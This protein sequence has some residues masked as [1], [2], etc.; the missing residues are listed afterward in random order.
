MMLALITIGGLAI[1][2]FLE[3][4]FTPWARSFGMWPTLTGRWIGELRTEDGRSQP[5]FFELSGGFRGRSTYINGRARV[6]DR[7]DAIRDFEVSGRPDNWRGTRFHFSPNGTVEIRP[8]LAAGRLEA[9]WSGDE[10]RGSGPLFQPGGVASASVSRDSPSPQTQ[11]AQLMLRRGSERDF[12]A[13]C[14]NAA[15]H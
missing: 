14:G 12:L 2:I 7:R 6:C 15:P 5:V 9:E 3:L 13:A 4:P 8:G 1:L 11:R 10:I